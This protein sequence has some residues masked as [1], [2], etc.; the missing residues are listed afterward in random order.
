VLGVRIVDGY[1]AQEVGA[2]ALECPESGLYHVHAESLIVEVLNAEGR[3]CAPGETGRVVVTD[4]HN[5]AT[6]LI[7]YELR[8]SAE[9]G[10]AAGCACGRR[11]PTLTRVLGR[12]RN[13]V[14]LPNGQRHWPL[15]GLHHYREVA[16]ILQYQLIQHDLENVEMRLVT[17]APLD[18][19]AEAHLREIVQ[20]ALGHPF[21]IRFSYVA[22]E[23]ARGAGGKFEEFV[24]R[25]PET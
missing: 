18:P 14:V 20:Q 8:D 16:K 10:P 7:R 17:E 19:A 1:S 25:V 15:V 23:L 2:I 12:Q 4:L 11:L 21:A 24:C 13:M 5:F 3:A 6:P 9:V 22:G